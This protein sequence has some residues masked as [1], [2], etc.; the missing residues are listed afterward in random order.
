MTGTKSNSL[1]ATTVSEKESGKFGMKSS[2]SNLSIY[3]GKIRILNIFY[4]ETA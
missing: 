4:N 3:F 1:L 2:I